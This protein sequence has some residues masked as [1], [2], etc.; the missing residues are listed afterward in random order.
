METVRKRTRL[1]VGQL[2]IDGAS[3]EDAIARDV[4]IRTNPSRLRLSRACIPPIYPVHVS[5]YPKESGNR[6]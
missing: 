3:N 1:G 6:V 5:R 4:L 2:R